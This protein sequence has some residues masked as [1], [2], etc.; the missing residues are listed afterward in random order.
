MIYTFTWCVNAMLIAFIYLKF[1]RLL[2]VQINTFTVV[3]LQRLKL[4]LYFYMFKLHVGH[5]HGQVTVTR[6]SYVNK[7]QVARIQK[8][9]AIKIKNVKTCVQLGRM[10]LS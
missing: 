4:L 9:Y 10:N 6:D 8:I 2:N 3:C 7:M 1:C 5:Y